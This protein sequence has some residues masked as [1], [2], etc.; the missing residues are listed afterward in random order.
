MEFHN[1]K[2]KLSSR[3]VG[4]WMCI[5]KNGQTAWPLG[6]LRTDLSNSNCFKVAQWTFEFTNNLITQLKINHLTQDFYNWTNHCHHLPFS[7]SLSSSVPF[8]GEWNH[9]HLSVQDQ[10]LG[11]ILD[12]SKNLKFTSNPNGE[13]YWFCPLNISQIY[14]FLPSIATTVLV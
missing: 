13:T 8:L 1:G 11:V 7:L 14:L 4:A 10:K 6:I 9:I 12:M 3:E 5:W 2:W